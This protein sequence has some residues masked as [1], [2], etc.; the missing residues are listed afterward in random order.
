MAVEVQPPMT[1]KEMI[2][3]FIKL[4]PEPFFS[5]MLGA[6]VGEFSHLFEIGERVD[7]LTKSEHRAIRRD[8]YSGESKTEGNPSAWRTKLSKA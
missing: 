8:N 3:E 4:L 5:Y 7:S 2:S 1:E 6:H